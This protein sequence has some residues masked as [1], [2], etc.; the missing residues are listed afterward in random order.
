[1]VWEDCSTDRFVDAKAVAA[2]F[3]LAFLPVTEGKIMRDDECARERF[4]RGSGRDSGGDE[5]HAEK[6]TLSDL[7]CRL[8][9]MGRTA[10]VPNIDSGYP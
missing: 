7:V 6:I 10:N 3:N 2:Q 4:G 5:S 9:P 8:T 1:M